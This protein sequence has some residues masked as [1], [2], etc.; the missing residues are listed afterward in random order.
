MYEEK[1][2]VQEEIVEYSSLYKNCKR[3]IQEWI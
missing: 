1:M 2:G 3:W